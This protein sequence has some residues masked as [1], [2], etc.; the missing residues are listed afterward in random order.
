MSDTRSTTLADLNDDPSLIDELTENQLVKLA[1]ES[2]D[3]DIPLAGNLRSIL[4][5]RASTVLAGRAE[6]SE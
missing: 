6:N 5:S 4:N 1:E 2:N 3:A